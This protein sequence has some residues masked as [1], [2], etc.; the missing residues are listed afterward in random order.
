[1]LFEHKCAKL[2]MVSQEILK[3]LANSV[4]LHHNRASQMLATAARRNNG[5]V[6]SSFGRTRKAHPEEDY[7]FSST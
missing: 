1:M 7:D 6:M 5:G 4:G 2:E 3:S